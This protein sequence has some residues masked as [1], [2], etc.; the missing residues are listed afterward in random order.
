MLRQEN[1]VNLREAFRRKNK[2]YLV[3]QYVEKNMLEILEEKPAG[4]SVEQVR[5]YIYQL[6]QAIYWCHAHDV[7]HRDIMPENLLVNP[8]DG[9]L[10]YVVCL[11]VLCFVQSIL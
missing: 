1:I 10:R 8:E 3:F 9:K 5:K 6:V 2:L 7:V 11:L 4:L